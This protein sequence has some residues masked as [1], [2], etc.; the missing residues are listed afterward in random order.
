MKI[1]LN[2]LYFPLLNFQLKIIQ[3]FKFRLFYLFLI[4]WNK[5]VDFIFILKNNVHIC[6]KLFRNERF[7]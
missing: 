2:I 4:N 6:A 1:G 7:C 5:K 3:Y